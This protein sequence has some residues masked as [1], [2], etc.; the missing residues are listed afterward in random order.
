MIR[1]GGYAR[2]LESVQSYEAPVFPVTGGDLLRLGIEK[3]PVLG[4]KLRELETLWIDSGFSLDHETLLDK[5][6]RNK[7]ND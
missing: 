7:M 6:D 4:E 3:G 1:A 5:L 2:L